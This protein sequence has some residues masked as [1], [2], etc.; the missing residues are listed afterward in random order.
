MLP[1]DALTD[2]LYNTFFPAIP[3][4]KNSQNRVAMIILRVSLSTDAGFF[5]VPEDNYS[6]HV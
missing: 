2:P 6:F 3:T 4:A 5:Q 1:T